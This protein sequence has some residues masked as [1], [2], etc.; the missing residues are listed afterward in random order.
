LLLKEELEHYCSREEACCS[1]LHQ[2]G[3]GFQPAATFLLLPSPPMLLQKTLNG[4]KEELAGFVVLLSQMQKQHKVQKGFPL[5]LCLF[6]N[7]LDSFTRLL[8][9]SRNQLPAVLLSLPLPA[10]KPS[11]SRF[12][13]V[14][15]RRRTP[16]NIRITA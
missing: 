14:P 10:G 4:L 8:W 3:T 15:P 11:W 16:E 5:A 9:D 2:T 1:G 7:E 12:S 6:M 13:L